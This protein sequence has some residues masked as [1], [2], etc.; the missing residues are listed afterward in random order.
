MSSLPWLP[1]GVHDANVG[2]NV[3]LL[4]GM[5]L[6]LIHQREFGGAMPM[7]ADVN[8]F[9]RLCRAVYTVSNSHLSMREAM[10]QIPC[11]FGLWHAYVH[12]VKRVYQKFMSFWAA[13][14]DPSLLDSTCD[15]AATR[16]YGHPKVVRLEHMVAAL[17]LCYT[18]E[19]RRKL[20]TLVHDK[21]PALG[22]SLWGT[23][24]QTLM[25][26]IS[27][28]VPALFMLGHRVRSFYWTQQIGNTG[29]QGKRFLEQCFV[30]LTLLEGN[31]LQ[32]T[33][34]LLQLLFLLGTQMCT[35]ASLWDLW[36]RNA[37]RL[38]F[39]IRSVLPEWNSPVT[40]LTV[41]QSCMVRWDQPR[42]R[43]TM[44]VHPTCLRFSHTRHCCACNG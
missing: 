15:P 30:F 6:F 31:E 23:V 11:V 37:W 7:L 38:A 12:C 2:S 22:E 5:D 41:S 16:V 36:Y 1:V 35:I 9:Y 28:Y 21:K 32:S 24:A 44:P 40:Q 26:F 13:L 20:Q 25:L 19:L 14:D 43:H 3:G 4:K 33:S 42:R 29:V 17:F 34:E 39:P 27:E 10:R 18:T 8:I